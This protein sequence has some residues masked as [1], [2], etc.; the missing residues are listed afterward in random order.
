[1]I[2]VNSNRWVFHFSMS[3][4]V[5]N[6][7]L[8]VRTD[9][10]L[11]PQNTSVYTGYEWL[12]DTGTIF[13]LPSSNSTPVQQQCR[14]L[15]SCCA[16]ARAQYSGQNSRFAQQQ[17]P[18]GWLRAARHAMLGAQHFSPQA[19]KNIA[20]LFFALGGE[21]KWRPFFLLRRRCVCV[22]F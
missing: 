12:F 21:K 6:F 10:Y 1:M 9:Q 14:A 22:F 17:P 19:K 7:W 16:V 13:L 15:I 3:E 8:S 11:V 4:V 20:R 18:R 2:E 5:E